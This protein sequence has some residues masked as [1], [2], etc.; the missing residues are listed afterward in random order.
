M[1]TGTPA[2][3]L[4]HPSRAVFCRCYIDALLPNGPWG[5]IVWE[6]DS[7][8]QSEEI[9]DRAT[10]YRRSE[11]LYEELLASGWTEILPRSNDR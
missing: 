1:N 3:R 2:W 4:Y 5:V 11:R 8:L 7:I 9:E 6:G 10:A